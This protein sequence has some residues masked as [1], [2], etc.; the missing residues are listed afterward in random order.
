MFNKNYTGRKDIHEYEVFDSLTKF[1]CDWF[2]CLHYARAKGY[3]YIEFNGNIYS[4]DS[5]KNDES[6]DYKKAICEKEDLIKETVIVKVKISKRDYDLLK[7]D[8]FVKLTENNT[9]KGNLIDDDYGNATL[10]L[11]TLKD[12]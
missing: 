10:L 5:Y 11:E 12:N 4:V 8:P 3:K 1:P 2:E 6:I 9:V 7:E